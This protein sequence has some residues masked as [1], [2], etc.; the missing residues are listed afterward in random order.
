MAASTAFA[1]LENRQD[2]PS[3]GSGAAAPLCSLRSRRGQQHSRRSSTHSSSTAATPTDAQHHEPRKQPHHMLHAVTRH[4]RDALTDLQLK[5]LAN[6]EA[7]LK[8]EAIISDLRRQLAAK[9]ALIHDLSAALLMGAAAENPSACDA[10]AVQLALDQE[11]GM[12]QGGRMEVRCMKVGSRRMAVSSGHI[13][14]ACTSHVHIGSKGTSSGSEGTSSGSEGTSSGSGVTSSGSG[15][16]T[17]NSSST[18][19]SVASLSAAG[20]ADEPLGCMLSRAEDLAAQIASVLQDHGG[21]VAT[22]DGHG[23][24]G[25]PSAAAP[26]VTS[27]AAPRVQTPDSL[28]TPASLSM[29]SPTSPPLA[30]RPDGS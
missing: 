7:L 2:V 25:A 26:A 22:D 20:M 14:S 8:Q 30:D 13:S 1:D 15:G 27:A 18:I 5:A 23:T 11:C 29:Q 9:S 3:R 4:L 16:A 10:A 12:Q 28:A 17:S 21:C 6:T 24:D 19:S